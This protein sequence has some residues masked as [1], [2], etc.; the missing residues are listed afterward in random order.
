VGISTDLAQCKMRLSVQ[1]EAHT[2]FI[3][4]FVSRLV[5]LHKQDDSRYVDDPNLDA[6]YV[7]PRMEEPE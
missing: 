7:E 4:T 1:R 3:T 2:I 6:G 5:V